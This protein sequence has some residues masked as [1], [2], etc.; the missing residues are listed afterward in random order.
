[1]IHYKL[2][3]ILRALKDYSIY[4]ILQHAVNLKFA[5]YCKRQ[6]CFHGTEIQIMILFKKVSSLSWKKFCKIL[7]EDKDQ[8]WTLTFSSIICSFTSINTFL[9]K[10]S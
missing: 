4:T 1:M 6:I 9:L 5:Q 10:L 2:V 7:T 8:D 3:Q